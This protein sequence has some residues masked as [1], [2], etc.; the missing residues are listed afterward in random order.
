MK[1]FAAHLVIL[2][3]DSFTIVPKSW[4]LLKALNVSCL[5]C[6][7][8]YRFSTCVVKSVK[9]PTRSTNE[10][11]IELIFYISL[12]I[13]LRSRVRESCV[14]LETVPSGPF[15]SLDQLKRSFTI[16][17]F[18]AFPGQSFPVHRVRTFPLAV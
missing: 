2:L 1:Y 12:F 17:K 14:F 4:E 18:S 11:F 16:A 7:T 8:A 15:V 9:S 13:P 3:S 5:K 6:E 10:E